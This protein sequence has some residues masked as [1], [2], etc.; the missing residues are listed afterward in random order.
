AAVAPLPDACLFA[1]AGE[2]DAV[3]GEALVD[4]YVANHCHVAHEP[5]PG[6]AHGRVGRPLVAAGAVEEIE[7]VKLQPLHKLAE[8]LRLEGR[9]RGI[10]QLLVSAPVA[11]TDAL[12]QPG[13]EL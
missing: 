4:A 6:T 8:R 5:H 11:A 7:A 12:Q 9:D 1:A 13:V 2:G 3:R 10:A